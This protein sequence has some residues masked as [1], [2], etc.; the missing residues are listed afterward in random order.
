MRY[1][2]TSANDSPGRDPKNWQF[3]GSND[4]STWTTVDTRTNETFSNRFQTKV[5]DFSND[6]PYLYYRINITANS[7]DSYIQL[8]EFQ[9][10]DGI[11]LP[12]PPPADMKSF[13][14]NG[15]SGL[16]AAKSNA[17]W[18][19]LKALTYSG[20]HLADGRAY[21]YNKLYDVDI[22]VTPNTE[23]S[24]YIAPEFT[25]IAQ[26]DY[27]STYA[28]VDLAFSDGTYLHSL[29]AVDQHGVKVNP[30]DQGNSKTLYNNQWNFK[31]SRIG[32]VAA[33]KTIKRILIAYDNP[34][35]VRGTGFK[36]RLTMSKSKGIPFPKPTTGFLNMSTSSE[37][38][39]RTA[40]SPG[41][42]I[43]RPLPYRTD[44]TSGYP[45]QMQVRIGLITTIKAITR[46]I[47]PPFRPL[48]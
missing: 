43:F 29:G 27:S 8:A 20:I 3:E 23:L 30:Q 26:M 11:V 40:H 14:S 18:S 15:P 46:T 41:A 21:S 33:G 22:T 28:A 16:Y 10:S 24:Y 34:A 7:G 2:L 48:P 4:G 35:A 47:S 9:L 36:G 37:A 12:P 45:K 39:N 42:I 31:T 6:T 17:G 38:H 25:D 19:G 13:I 32:A 5:Y 44:S 1:A